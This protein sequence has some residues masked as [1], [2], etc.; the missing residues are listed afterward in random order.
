MTNRE[1][2][3]YIKSE[4]E[5]LS[6]ANWGNDKDWQKDVKFIASEIDR[7]LEDK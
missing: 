2:L 3:E 7:L 5:G 4:L 1:K 6:K